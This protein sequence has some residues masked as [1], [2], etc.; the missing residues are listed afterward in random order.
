MQ[1]KRYIVKILYKKSTTLCGFSPFLLPSLPPYLCVRTSMYPPGWPEGW[2][3]THSL[4]PM[5]LMPSLSVSLVKY[6]L[7]VMHRQT[8]G[9]YRT[10]SLH[11]LLVG[12]SPEDPSGPSLCWLN[13]EPCP[14]LWPSGGSI[15]SWCLP[16]VPTY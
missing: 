6:T 7:K 2:P 16:Q 5:S 8:D 13:C 4:L 15:L 10:S 12:R 9:I 1:M 11:C 3:E 14:S